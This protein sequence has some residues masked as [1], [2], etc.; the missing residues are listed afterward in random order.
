MDISE[1]ESHDL[2][3]SSKQPF[4]LCPLETKLLLLNPQNNRGAWVSSTMWSAALL[5]RVL[6]Y[7]FALNISFTTFANLC[8]PLFQFLE[9]RLRI[10]KHLAQAPNV[11]LELQIVCVYVCM[12]VHVPA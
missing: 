12:C 1:K 5:Q 3:Y 8:E 10:W 9:E 11:T 6:F 2:T 7:S 4:L